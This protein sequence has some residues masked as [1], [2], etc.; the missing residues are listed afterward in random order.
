MVEM[1]FEELRE[2]IH[3]MPDNVIVRVTV[4]EDEDGQ[5]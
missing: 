5:E 4:S 2:Y 1:T 3:G